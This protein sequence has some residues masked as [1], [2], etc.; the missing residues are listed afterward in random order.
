MEVKKLKFIGAASIGSPKYLLLQL[1][2][3]KI[4]VHEK[5]ANSLRP[6]SIEVN[7][8]K[9]QLRLAHQLIFT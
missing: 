9:R 7:F 4:V 5:N 1:R 6:I 2:E 3:V 8:S